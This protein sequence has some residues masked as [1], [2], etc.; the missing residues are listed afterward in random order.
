MTNHG[1]PESEARWQN[2]LA[3]NP[4]YKAWMRFGLLLSK[5]T[6]P[7][8]LGIAF[9]LVITP[10][11]LFRKLAQRDTLK[12]R[13]DDSAETYRIASRPSSPQEFERPY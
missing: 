6:T 9:Y 12:R 10:I 5:I 2:R 7:L 11:G 1:N 3:L 13:F 4:V 8:I